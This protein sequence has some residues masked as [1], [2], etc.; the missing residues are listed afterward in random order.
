MEAARPFAV[1]NGEFNTGNRQAALYARRVF[2]LRKLAVKN[3]QNRYEIFGSGRNN[4]GS[5]SVIVA[6]SRG[7]WKGIISAVMARISSLEDQAVLIA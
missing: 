4:T 2:R 1:P 5:L 3:S 6:N 7:S